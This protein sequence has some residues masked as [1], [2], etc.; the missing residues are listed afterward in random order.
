MTKRIN[1]LRYLS[2]FLFVI[3]GALCFSCGLL[4]PDFD[5][6]N[7]SEWYPMQLV[8]DETRIEEFNSEWSRFCSEYG[9]S[10]ENVAIDSLRGH[11]RKYF[12]FDIPFQQP[13]ESIEKFTESVAD[14]LTKWYRLVSVEPF[15]I[16]GID[17]K[18]WNG[19]Y[20]A[21]IHQRSTYKH[22]VYKKSRTLGVVGMMVD[23][24]GRLFRW[25]S[26]LVPQLPVPDEPLISKYEALNA[27]HGQHYTVESMGGSQERIVLINHIT[28]SAL[29]VYIHRIYGKADVTRL[30]YHL[31]WRFTTFDGDF[32][33]D[34]Q[35]GDFINF[36]Q[37]WRSE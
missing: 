16:S 6:A 22:P 28:E 3:F 2:I 17:S 10:S 25:T 29:E 5:S 26:D 32:F 21:S 9:I 27:L 35:T 34:S 15:I 19:F 4:S 1:I 24:P 30:D 33:I 36:I 31:V 18:I 23:G 14:F 7:V 11:L 12:S 8:V 13:N 37:S 20:T